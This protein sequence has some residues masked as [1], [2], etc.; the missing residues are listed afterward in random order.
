[1]CQVCSATVSGNQFRFNDYWS[2]R[3]GRR[4]EELAWKKKYEVF[5]IIL[6]LFTL[7][8]S[9]VFFP[10]T[11]KFFSIRVENPIV[12]VVN[13]KK[14]GSNRL[15]P[16]TLAVTAKSEWIR[17]SNTWQIWNAVA[18]MLVKSCSHGL[19][20]TW[21][22]INNHLA[23]N[24]CFGRTMGFVS[25][26]VVMVKFHDRPKTGNKWHCKK[27]AAVINFMSSFSL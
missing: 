3:P 6:L 2:L 23:L 13:K 26:E 19:T 14:L 10:Q 16:S 5:G 15:A 20:D 1:M 27:Q 11:F 9:N 17:V 21:W 18:E 24:Y 22:V 4:G 7:Q 25:Q 8:L 12:L